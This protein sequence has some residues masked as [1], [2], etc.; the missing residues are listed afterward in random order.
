MSARSTAGGW[1]AARTSDL[2]RLPGDEERAYREHAAAER[3]RSF[4]PTALLGLALFDAY[5]LVD[6]L[7]APQVAALSAA[8]RL[9]VVTPFALAGL[10]LRRR[11]LARRPASRVDGPFV[12]ACAVLSVLVLGVVQRQDPAALDGG[13]LLGVQVIT[14]FYVVLV[15]SDVRQAA[16]VVASLLAAV[17]AVLGTGADPLWLRVSVAVP[18]VV[19]GAFGLVMAA[20]VEAGA[21]RAFRAVRRERALA[22]ELAAANALLARD[23]GADALTGVLNRRGL[24]DALERLD[25]APCGVLM[26]D[27]D[28]FKAFND[29]AGH[30]AGDECLRRVAGAVA[31]ALR[32]GDV[33]A[34]YGGEEFAVLLPGAGAVEALA[35]ARRVRAAVAALGLAH[36][37]RPD[38]REV[39]TVSV[40]AARAAGARAGLGAADAALYEAKA[41]GRDA[42]RL[43]TGAGAVARW[44]S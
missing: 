36:P 39:V 41:A 27:V 7:L 40:G 3:A 25:G 32:P 10:L 18:V 16:L 31:T 17:A 33:V 44:A 15:R 35:V 13:Y 43:G 28:H 29:R 5:A 42:V 22:A 38:G 21:R 4:A 11:H 8:L 2:R 34:R 19:C 24:E 30:Q 23:A 14:L 1:W 9:G 20:D 37:A 26:V 12:A 6:V